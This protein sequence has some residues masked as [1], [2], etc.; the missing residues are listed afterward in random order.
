M[1]RDHSAIWSGTI[2]TAALETAARQWQN[3]RILKSPPPRRDTSLVVPR[4]D[5]EIPLPS[6][7]GAKTVGLRLLFLGWCDDQGN[8]VADEHAGLD[9]N[10]AAFETDAYYGAS[11][12]TLTVTD[13]NGTTWTGDCQPLSFEP[14]DEDIDAHGRQIIRAVLTIKIPKLLTVVP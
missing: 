12:K 10:I 9:A 14:G 6:R 4:A 7:L 1:F 3:P 5:G 2:G 13:P 11:T 8:P